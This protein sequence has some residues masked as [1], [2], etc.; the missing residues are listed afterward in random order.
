[1]SDDDKGGAETKPTGPW[2]VALYVMEHFPMF[3]FSIAIIGALF[4]GAGFIIQQST[5]AQRALLEAQEKIA[6]DSE[7]H[8]KELAALTDAANQRIAAKEAEA[9]QA[10]TEANQRIAAKEAEADLAIAEAN[11]QITAA[12]IRIAT[13]KA[14]AH[15]EVQ[16]TLLDA[17]KRIQGLVIGQLNSMDELEALRTATSNELNA[18][19][20]TLRTRRLE[21]QAELD[22]MRR[23]VE[24]SQVRV[25]LRQ[26]REMTETED[27]YY[28]H[29]NAVQLAKS[30]DFSS[31][32]QT[33]V[34][35]EAL[36]TTRD[37]T[38]IAA[39]TYALYLET[40]DAQWR[41]RFIA[42]LS[43]LN[44][45]R[46][47]WL[48]N[49]TCCN[50]IALEDWRRLAA[51]LL[52]QLD[53]GSLDARRYEDVVSLLGNSMPSLTWT[54]DNIADL[55]EVWA[56]SAELIDILKLSQSQPNTYRAGYALSYLSNIDRAAHH[57]WAYELLNSPSL[58]EFDRERLNERIAE[59]QDW[60]IYL[61]S[62]PV[63]EVRAFWTGP[64]L[65]EKIG[66]YQEHGTSELYDF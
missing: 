61:A 57:V 56:F 5:D 6:R 33:Q 31:E 36:A 34:L 49:I 62:P 20:A 46:A 18:Q 32:A 29:E 41:D 8:R 59:P 38:R 12:D 14:E 4:Y 58:E 42:A 25:G 3:A 52:P 17:S 45:L 53:S 50:D 16:D 9:D 28:I 22:N 26:I 15:E 51:T 2:D 13:A 65:A 55:P 19:I 7:E 24:V 1:M 54:D 23:E 66:L 64:G 10:I 37:P 40:R 47:E 60:E 63:D 30:V 35:N 11:A 21:L 39:I 43:D 27:N 48:G 44:A